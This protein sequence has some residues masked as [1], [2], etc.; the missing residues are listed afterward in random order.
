MLACLPQERG[1]RVRMQGAMLRWA[2]AAAAAISAR[3]EAAAA[4]Q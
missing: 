4:Q 3:E 2:M 1:R